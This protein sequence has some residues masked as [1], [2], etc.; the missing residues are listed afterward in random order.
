M[1]WG[2]L[3]SLAGLQVPTSLQRVVIKPKQNESKIAQNFL[4]WLVRTFLLQSHAFYK[5][6]PSTATGKKKVI[7][8]LYTLLPGQQ[9][10]LSIT[11]YWI[12]QIKHAVWL[13]CLRWSLQKPEA[14]FIFWLLLQRSHSGSV[15]DTLRR[16]LTFCPNV[17]ISF[18]QK[19]ISVWLCGVA[20]WG[21]A[22]WHLEG[23]A[24][25]QVS[26]LCS[27]RKDENTGQMEQWVARQSSRARLC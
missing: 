25:W 3:I 22:E 8:F 18:Q 12:N 26:A 23:P 6:K 27:L 19:F 11:V 5:N 1:I 17:G 16:H 4:Y 21:L 13:D 7:L 10:R 20:S 14:S 9:S 15:C 2:K 24:S